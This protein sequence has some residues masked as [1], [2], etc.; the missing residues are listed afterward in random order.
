MLPIFL[1]PSPFET[2]MKQ[3]YYPVDWSDVALIVILVKL[4]PYTP[5]VSAEVT[6]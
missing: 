2:W 1:K 6:L 4:L 5:D 3:H